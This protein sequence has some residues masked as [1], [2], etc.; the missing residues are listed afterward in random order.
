M[1]AAQ[2]W[3]AAG[4]GDQRGEEVLQDSLIIGLC[5]LGHVAQAKALFDRATALAAASPGGS[6]PLNRGEGVRAGSTPR[7]GA[8][9]SYA[10]MPSM[11]ACNALMLEL[12]RQV[13][14]LPGPARALRQGDSPVLQG[15]CS[16]GPLSAHD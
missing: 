7:E 14:S 3:R 12:I 11:P 4:N 1:S 5:S 2:R 15:M 9:E 6:L 10:R 8:S 16:T 13:G